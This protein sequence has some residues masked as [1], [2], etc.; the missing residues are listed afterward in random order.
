MALSNGTDLYN[1][2][3]SITDK[4]NGYQLFVQGLKGLIEYGKAQ[5]DPNLKNTVLTKCTEY[6][7]SA[8]KM[9]ANIKQEESN[10]QV[11]QNNY[12]NSQPQGNNY[13]KPSPPQ[14]NNQPAS[15]T[16]Q[17]PLTEGEGDK[18]KDKM[19]ET[20]GEAIVRETPNVK[21]SDI[22]GLE[23]AKESLQEAV[24]LPMKFPEIF[25]GQ[26]KPWKG[27]LLYGV[28]CQLLILASWNWKNL[29]S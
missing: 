21:W 25:V 2:A 4:K 18:E 7:T 5:E 28:Y 9:K 23:K 14:G 1:G 15:P 24:I 29:F 26:R 27:I 10:Q 6:T 13:S 19:K 8:E 12:Q 22:A 20:L 17:K 11:P 3:K 16:K